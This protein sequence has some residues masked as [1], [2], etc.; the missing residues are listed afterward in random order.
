MT[1][2]DVVDD[3]L[4]NVVELYDFPEE[5]KTDHLVRNLPV[6]LIVFLNVETYVPIL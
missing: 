6:T 1:S 2:S 4:P 5:Y 3:D